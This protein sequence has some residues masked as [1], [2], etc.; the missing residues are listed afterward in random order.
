MKDLNRSRQEK[1]ND[2]IRRLKKGDS[3][4]YDATN[5]WFPPRPVI[6]KDEKVLKKLYNTDKEKD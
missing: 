2:I 1:N 3:L 4:Q 6:K 5:T